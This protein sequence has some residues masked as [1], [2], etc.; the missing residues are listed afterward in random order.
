MRSVKVAEDGRWT[1]ACAETRLTIE[2]HRLTTVE[3]VY[4]TPDHR[5]V[6]DTFIWQDHDL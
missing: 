6:L 5:N 3:P 2:G 1:V 4:R